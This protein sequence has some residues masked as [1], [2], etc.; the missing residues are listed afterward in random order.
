MEV[1]IS[2]VIDTDTDTPR[3]TSPPCWS[4]VGTLYGDGQSVMPP[5]RLP[6]GSS[7]QPVSMISAKKI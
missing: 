2:L 4:A 7:V 5:R 3:W 1:P 6:R